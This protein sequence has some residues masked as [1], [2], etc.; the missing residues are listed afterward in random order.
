MPENMSVLDKI[1]FVRSCLDK[2]AD[3]QG[4]AKCAYI[5]IIDDAVNK[6]RNDILILQ[7]QVKDKESTEE[8]EIEFSVEPADP[9]TMSQE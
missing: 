9:E 5:Y 2:L 1:D 4:R 7:E 3:S 8:P 6:I